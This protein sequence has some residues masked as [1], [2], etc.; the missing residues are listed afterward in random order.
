MLQGEAPVAGEVIGVGVRL[1]RPD[2][3]DAALLGLF[4]VLLDREGRV[5]D[6]RGFRLRVADQV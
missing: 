3:A 1:D 5:D 6:D 4:E 2:D